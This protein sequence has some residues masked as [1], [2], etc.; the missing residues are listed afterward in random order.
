[1]FALSA[2]PHSAALAYANGMHM[3]SKFY[4]QMHAK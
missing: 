4:K 2:V 3:N 1:M